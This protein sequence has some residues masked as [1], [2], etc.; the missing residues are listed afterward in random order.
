LKSFTLG[1]SSAAPVLQE[2]GVRPNE[3]TVYTND[4]YAS[5]WLVT[6]CY[7]HDQAEPC[8]VCK[9]DSQL[10]V[11]NPCVPHLSYM[12]D[13]ILM[14]WLLSAFSIGLDVAFA[15]RSRRA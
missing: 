8:S 12:V 5:G 1:L 14:L 7:E 11:I 15:L 13:L 2:H 9:A 6:W 4:N 10:R 3:T